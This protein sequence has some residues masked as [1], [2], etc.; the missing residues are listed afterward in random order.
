MVF[1]NYSSHFFIGTG[2]YPFPIPFLFGTGNYPFP[3]M[4]VIN[5]RQ[6]KK[7]MKEKLQICIA[8]T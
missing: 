7:H 5:Q 6:W 1:V 3:C 2:N 8:S 4:Y